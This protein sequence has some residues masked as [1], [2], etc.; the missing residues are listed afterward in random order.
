MDT[1]LSLRDAASYLGVAPITVRRLLA[2]G[3]GPRH[4][5]VGKQLRFTRE[6]VADYLR[7]RE[8]EQEVVQVKLKA[9]FLGE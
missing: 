4:F 3:D 9:E 8:Q 7:Q 6:A 5:R 2:R 1:P